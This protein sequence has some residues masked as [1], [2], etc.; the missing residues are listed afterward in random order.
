MKLND[1]LGSE[2]GSQRPKVLVLGVIFFLAVLFSAVQDV[3]LD[4]WALTMLQR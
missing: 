4:G 1:L 3:A 2:D